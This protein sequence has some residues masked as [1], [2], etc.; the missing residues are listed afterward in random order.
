MPSFIHDIRRVLGRRD[1]FRMGALFVC[2]WVNSFFELACLAAFPAFIQ[3]LFA[4]GGMSVPNAG[5]TLAVGLATFLTGRLGL[6]A[7]PQNMTV[8]T[9]A[10]LLLLNALRTGWMYFSIS[11]QERFLANRK[12]EYSGRLIEGYLAADAS[13]VSTVP[14]L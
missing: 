8:A 12:I 10:A 7:T 4:A 1:T 14:S 5:G 6:E 13:L 2:L 3:I 9:G 11:L